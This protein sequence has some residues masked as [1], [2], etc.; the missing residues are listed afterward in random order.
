[1]SVTFCLCCILKLD[2]LIR[3][4]ESFYG[5]LTWR[6]YGICQKSTEMLSSSFSIWK[7]PGTKLM[8]KL[9]FCFL[10]PRIFSLHQR[11]IFLWQNQ[12][13]E[14]L[15]YSEDSWSHL[16]C[17]ITS[18]VIYIV[19]SLKF[20]INYIHRSLQTLNQGQVKDDYIFFKYIFF[21]PETR[22]HLIRSAVKRK[23]S[24]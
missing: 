10:V 16:L 24:I 15:Q 12:A 18:L 22:F 17:T 6:N 5:A 1:M 20:F 23:D 8:I 21:F 19:Q 13:N 3:L 7:Q 2:R 4:E 14:T 11:Q 9:A